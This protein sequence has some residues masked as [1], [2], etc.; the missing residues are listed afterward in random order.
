MIAVVLGYAVFGLLTGI[1]VGV[2]GDGWSWVPAGAE[3]AIGLIAGTL[4]PLTLLVGLVYAARCAGRAI[5]ASFATLWRAW[6]PRRVPRA[7]ARERSGPHVYSKSGCRFEICPGDD[8]GHDSKAMHCADCGDSE[9]SH[10]RAY[11]G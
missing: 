2:E 11:D 7:V 3:A 6:R 9:W 10:D 1:F 8:C 5:E 4:W